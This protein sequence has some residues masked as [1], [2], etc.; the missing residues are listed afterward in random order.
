MSMFSNMI[1]GGYNQMEAK[2]SSPLGYNPR[3]FKQSIEDQIA[4]HKNK[5]AE[6]EAVKESLTPEIEKFVEAMQKLG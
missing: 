1:Q 3:T 4:H 6:L 2:S 5:L